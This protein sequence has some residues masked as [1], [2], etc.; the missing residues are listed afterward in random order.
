MTAKSFVVDRNDPGE[1]NSYYSSNAIKKKISLHTFQAK[2]TFSFILTKKRYR[3]LQ[4]S[5][6]KIMALVDSR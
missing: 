1:D 4:F 5:L 2:S 3:T 6:G